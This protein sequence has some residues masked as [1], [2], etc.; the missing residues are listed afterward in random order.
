MMLMASGGFLFFGAGALG[1]L[2][3]M[4]QLQL[5]SAGLVTVP[6]RTSPGPVRASL[7][8]PLLPDGP[9]AAS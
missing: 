4:D 8:G 1:L 3:G 7:N 9:P 5:W 6:P 2:E